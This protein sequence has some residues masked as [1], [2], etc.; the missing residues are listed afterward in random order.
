MRDK[1]KNSMG[2]ISQTR[3]CDTDIAISMSDSC[4]TNRKTGY[5]VRKRR[6]R[7]NK[8]TGFQEKEKEK[9]H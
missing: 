3:K 2:I 7:H 8:K 4:L 5:K 1:D 9:I 6:N